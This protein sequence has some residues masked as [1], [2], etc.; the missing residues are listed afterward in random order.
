MNIE[1]FV[2]CLAHYFGIRILPATQ[3]EILVLHRKAC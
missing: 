2:G 1:F 3:R